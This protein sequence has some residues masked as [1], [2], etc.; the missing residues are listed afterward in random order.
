MG[1]RE[2]NYRNLVRILVHD[3]ANPLM[4]ILG[5]SQRGLRDAE[6][7][8]RENLSKI[9]RAAE[10]IEQLLSQVRE[11]ECINAGYRSIEGGPVDLIGLFAEMEATFAGLAQ[12]RQ[13]GLQ[14]VVNHDRQA[15]AELSSL[16]EVV[17]PTL[18][19][20]ALNLAPTGHKVM[21]SSE[22]RG[23]RIALIINVENIAKSGIPLVESYIDAYGGSCAVVDGSL[24]IL[25]L[26]WLS[27]EDPLAA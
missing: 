12:R 15:Y 4:I 19:G 17:L 2:E 5:V 21:L 8:P 22:W 7:L 9:R 3:I 14:C 11:A 27:I 13:V 1:R 24:E 10:Q 18:L 26:D 23:D 20:K 16:A 25:L 6:G